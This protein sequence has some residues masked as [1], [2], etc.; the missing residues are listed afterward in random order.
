MWNTN[1]MPFAAAILMMISNA[2]RRKYRP[3]PPTTNVLPAMHVSFHLQFYAITLEFGGGETVEDGLDEVVEIM[4]L[5][6]HGDF[7]TQAAGAGL[8]AVERFGGDLGDR[9]RHVAMWI[10]W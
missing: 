3:S 6:E 10:D 7:F 1:P 4:V 5:L 9:E 8:L 2:S